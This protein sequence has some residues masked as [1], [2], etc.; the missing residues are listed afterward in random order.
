MQYA[1]VLVLQ[2]LSGELQEARER[3]VHLEGEVQHSVQLVA[4][5]ADE[6]L[7]AQQVPPRT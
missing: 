1:G 7:R 3:I 4:Q 5:G 2:N 6:L